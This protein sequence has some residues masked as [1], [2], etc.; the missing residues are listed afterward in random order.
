MHTLT[1]KLAEYENKL[2]EIILEWNDSETNAKGWLVIDSLHNGAAGGGT[3]MRLGLDKNEVISLAK[4]M[5]MKFAMSAMPIGGAKSG[6]NFDP[7]DPRK[8]DVLKRWYQAIHPLLKNYYGTGGDLN[9][10]ELQEVI[11]TTSKLGILHPQEG[12]LKG[13]LGSS[14]LQEDFK[15]R[16]I[17]LQIGV[18]KIIEEQKYSPDITKRYTIAD[19]ITGYGVAESVRYCYQLY[20]GNCIGKKVLIQGY[21]NVGAAAAYYLAMFGCKIVGI[22]VLQCAII[23]PE[24]F[25]LEELRILLAERQDITSTKIGK[26]LPLNK[27]DQVW[28]TKVNIF[29]PAAASRLIENKHIEQMLD[30]GLEL[31]SSGANIPFNDKNIFYGPICQNVDERISVLPDFVSGCGMAETFR[32]LME[33]DVDLNDE[34]IFNN[35]SVTVYNLLQQAYKINSNNTGITKTFLQLALNKLLARDK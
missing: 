14:L 19:M 7:T 18:S 8:E 21:G 35:I 22:I 27:V 2:P 9:V 28:Q 11:P 26:I 34:A 25:S 24:G 23:K 29:I 5:G 10:D 30:N 17:Q 32:Y 1:K 20:Y 16:L 33:K 12:I 31:I 15:K 13:Y 4:T 3:R 6:I